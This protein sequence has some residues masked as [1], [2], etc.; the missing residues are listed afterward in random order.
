MLIVKNV[1]FPVTLSVESLAY[2]LNW[3]LEFPA[4]L[5]KLKKYLPPTELFLT[6]G[7]P[8]VVV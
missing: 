5:V 3:I 1:M 7:V 8:V 2:H 4:W 6:L